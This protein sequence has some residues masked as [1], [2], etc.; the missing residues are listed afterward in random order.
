MTETELDQPVI[1][2]VEYSSRSGR[3]EKKVKV[4]VK[5]ERGSSTDGRGG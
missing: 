3:K 5:G 1:D 2:S 4:K